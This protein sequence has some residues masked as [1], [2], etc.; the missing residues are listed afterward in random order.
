[1]STVQKQQARPVVCGFCQL[2]GLL[3]KTTNTKRGHVC[4]PCQVLLPNME[5]C[6]SLFVCRKFR[7]LDDNWHCQRCV[8]K[9]D[10]SK[11]DEL[12][13]YDSGLD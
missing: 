1:M 13:D 2:P 12:I 8:L 5:W 11:E 4:E 3:L 9:A 10:P 6:M 7:V